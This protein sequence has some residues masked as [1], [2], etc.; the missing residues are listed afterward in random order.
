MITNKKEPCKKAHRGEKY[1]A[2]TFVR[3]SIRHYT[4]NKIEALTIM[5]SLLVLHVTLLKR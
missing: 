2:I 5:F 3:H 4:E 1:T